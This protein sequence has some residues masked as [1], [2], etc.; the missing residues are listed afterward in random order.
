MFPRKHFLLRINPKHARKIINVSDS[1][2]LIIYISKIVRYCHINVWL[3]IRT[4][5]TLY[6]NICNSICSSSVKIDT[7]CNFSNTQ[8][9]DD[10]YFLCIKCQVPFSIKRFFMMKIKMINH[11]ISFFVK[12]YFHQK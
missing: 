3:L 5:Y 4:L 2:G 9:F 1:Y 8:A 7:F 11:I 6:C 12:F 10:F